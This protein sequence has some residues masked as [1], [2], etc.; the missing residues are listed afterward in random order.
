M[1]TP[2]AASPE[3][4]LGAPEETPLVV[5]PAGKA[6]VPIE[7]LLTSTSAVQSDPQNVDNIKPGPVHD[8]SSL[9]QHRQAG[10]DYDGLF[11]QP[12]NREEFESLR[13]LTDALSVQNN[14]LKAELA[15]HKKMKAEKEE[16]ELAQVLAEMGGLK[17]RI[18]GLM[19]EKKGGN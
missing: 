8:T 4:F 19:K 16:G 17:Q 6:F 13:Y 10:N 15:L 18:E 9:A 2:H 11:A 12:I 1:A 5:S 3:T 14:A 7:S